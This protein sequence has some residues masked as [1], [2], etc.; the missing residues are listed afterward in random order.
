MIHEILYATVVDIW[1]AIFWLSLLLTWTN[2]QNFLMF[3]IAIEIALLA[4]SMFFLFEAAVLD[5]MLGM[6]YALFILTIAAAESAIGLSIIVLCHNLRGSV[7][8]KDKTITKT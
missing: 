5:D 1:V 8:C 7:S 2:R 4:L 6:L 3:L